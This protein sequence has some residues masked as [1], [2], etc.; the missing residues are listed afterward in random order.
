MMS[1]CLVHHNMLLG[2]LPGDHLTSSDLLTDQTQADESQVS[3]MISIGMVTTIRLRR[4]CSSPTLLLLDA[5][6]LAL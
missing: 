6:L 4:S 3:G 5:L 2:Q 1:E